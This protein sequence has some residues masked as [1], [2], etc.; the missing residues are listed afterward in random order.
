MSQP[1]WYLDPTGV[2]GQYRY[3]TGSSWSSQGTTTPGSAP[4]G[5]QDPSPRNRWA[6]GVL[7]VVV[8]IAVAIWRTSSPGSLEAGGAQDTNSAT[9]TVSAWDEAATSSA[10]EVACPEPGTADGGSARA[11]RMRS[12]NISVPTIAGW[13]DPAS[14]YVSGL[15]D[16]I[17][18]VRPVTQNWRADSVVGTTLRQHFPT[19][20][21]AARALSECFVTPD[22]YPEMTENQTLVTEPVTVDGH[23]GYWVRTKVSV[24]GQG[25][26]ITGDVIDVVAIDTGNPL[27]L[28]VYLAAA[29]IGNATIQ[30]E[31]DAVRAAIQ[32]TS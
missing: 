4:T 14:F 31:V 1:G 29:P 18:Q 24:S 28:G 13:A 25:P 21:R 22:N 16:T 7:L 17:A 20:Q 9:P 26:T 2:P 15:N 10:H 5:P 8:I 32:V 30:A 6:I 27:T 23:A 3:W 12:G 11:G 19:P